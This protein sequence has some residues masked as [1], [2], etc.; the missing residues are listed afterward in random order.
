MADVDLAKTLK[1]LKPRYKFF[2]GIDS[3]PEKSQK[4]E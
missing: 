2:A 4:V 3:D 1:K